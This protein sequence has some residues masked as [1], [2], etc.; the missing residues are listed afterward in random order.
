MRFPDFQL[1]T[2]IITCTIVSILFIF[3]SFLIMR[4]ERTYYQKE[5]S[6]KK[7]KLSS[8]AQAVA[9]KKYGV[10]CHALDPP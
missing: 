4:S 9:N 8:T 1:S 3:V 2:F 5:M 6:F 10:T 7:N